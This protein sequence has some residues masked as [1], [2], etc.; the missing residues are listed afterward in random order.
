MLFIPVR[1]SLIVDVLSAIGNLHRSTTVSHISRVQLHPGD[2]RGKLT[3]L[4]CIWRQNATRRVPYWKVQCICGT[5]WEIRDADLISSTKPTQ[6]CR[7]C[8]HRTHG[9]AS[10]RQGR[11]TRL[12]AIWSEMRHRCN[13]PRHRDYKNYGGRHI[14]VCER[15]QTSFENF[16]NDMGEP[17]TTQHTLD[18]RNNDAGYNP[19]NCRWATQQ[20]QHQ[21]T[22]RTRW[23]TYR[24]ECLPLCEWVQRLCISTETLRYHLRKERSMSW[25][26]Q[27]FTTYRTTSKALQSLVLG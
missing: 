12:Y 20:E 24:N 16:H 21:N 15:W 9:Q 8:A 6:A 19:E 17:P 3:L 14:S 7:P 26:V 4:E 11:V 22:R 13:N 5:Q 25:I 27:H 10:R 1:R 23:L 2:I 18:R